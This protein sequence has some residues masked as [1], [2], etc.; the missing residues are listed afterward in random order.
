M[1]KIEAVIFDWAGTTVDFGSMAPVQAFIRAFE[2]FGI[3]PTVWEVRMPMGKLKWDHIHEMLQMPRIHQEWIRVQGRDWTREDVDQ[4]YRVSEEAILEILPA[5]AQ[6]KPY[7]PDAVASLRER[8]IKI[9]STTGYTDEMMEIVSEAARKNGYAPD[10]CF[11]PNSV[12]DKGR[13]YPYMIFRNLEALGISSVESAIKVGDTLA[14]IREGKNAG[15]ISVGVVDGSSVMGLSEEEYKALNAEERF[16]LEERTRKLYLESG[17]D[18]VI[19]NFSE[20]E[21]LIL[22]LEQMAANF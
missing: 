3:T 2:K 19:Q 12:G 1:K 5:Y 20:L 21:D 15:M 11:T 10:A 22:D 9:G 8:G 17:A 18:Y 7:V 14:D 16:A 6:V 4:V 13:P